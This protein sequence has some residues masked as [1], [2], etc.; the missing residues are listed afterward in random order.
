MD[1]SSLID[2]FISHHPV[3][4]ANALSLASA[5]EA[6]NLKVKCEPPS[7]EWPHQVAD[8]LASVTQ[9]KIFVAWITAEY[10]VQAAA[11]REFMIAFAAASAR[12]Q[13]RERIVAIDALNTREA[14]LPEIL[15]AGCRVERPQDVNA[16]AERIASQLTRVR[17]AIEA[18][19][20]RKVM[21][22]GTRDFAGRIG[23]LWQMH[24]ALART[25]TNS[26]IVGLT[27]DG[28]S[29][30]SWLVDE[31]ARTFE[32]VYS[33]GI[34]RL[35]AGW[36]D[37]PTPTDFE[38]VRE[39]VWRQLALRLGIE[40]RTLTLEQLET[41]ITKRLNEIDRP[42][43]WIV[44]H[45]PAGQA[46]DAVRAWFAPTAKGATIFACRCDDYVPLGTPVVVSGIDDESAR[47]LLERHKPMA[48]TQELA[49]GRQLIE[50]LGH[51]AL[52]LHLAAARLGRS[53][54]DRLLL[55]LAA[56]PTQAAQLADALAEQLSHPQLVGIAVSVHRS[57]VHLSAHARHAL[58]LAAV[59]A[60]APVP[61]ALVTTALA[62][63][64]RGSTTHT[65]V[66]NTQLAIDEILGFGLAQRTSDDFLSV[67]PLVRT[68]TLAIDKEHE[69]TAAHDL[70]IATLA[71][72]LPQSPEPSDTNPY[73]AWIP[74]IL[75]L[76]RTA[77]PSTQL[78]E[79]NAWLS[80]FERL[81]S[82]KSGNRRAVT[83]LESGDFASAQQLLDMELA[84][85]RMGLG[86]DHLQTAAPV[87]NLAVALSLRGD[88][89]RAKALLEQ[90][91]DV[92]RK[93]L[94]DKHRDLLT[95]LNN[96]GVVLWHEGDQSKARVI[97]ERVVE[98]RQQLLGDTHPDTLVSMRNLAVVLRADGEYVAARNLLEHVV[99]ARRKAL[100]TQHVDTCTAMASL[101]ETLREH[102]EAILARIS[103]TLKLD[104]PMLG[105]DGAARPA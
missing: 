32:S 91:I 75:H 67:T 95:P 64:T 84:S 83:M 27:G 77:T 59:L 3:D 8:R 11:Q 49:G 105:H 65:S 94:G 60:N 71:G 63:H 31:Y 29:G 46:L 40:T 37:K 10:C 87:N 5:L 35:D 86:N 48:T 6:R 104:G 21:E 62:Q 39:F 43:L 42:Y 72:E 24:E 41:R 50:Q 70:L 4:A 96:L 14:S 80:R 44:D 25:Q 99:E 1:D 92:R 53:T 34:F 7:S 36:F 73:A 33:G 22:P 69:I 88:F 89:G 56:P 103:D 57:I 2:V 93:A 100:G 26:S 23:H 19:P 74:H 13:T 66:S 47:L 15:R 58:R 17:D 68:A 82:L 85:R 28:G 18:Q 61:L 45:V 20:S 52:S 12:S 90:A 38:A 16:I 9:A 78:I 81:G 30:K 102:S 101:A 79:I 55:Q 97:F 54:Y 98:L 76:V 51:H